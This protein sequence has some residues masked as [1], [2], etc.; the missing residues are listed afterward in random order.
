VLFSARKINKH[1][2][3]TQALRDVDFAV[4]AGTVHALVGENGAGKSTLSKIVAGV[5]QPDSGEFLWNGKRV[6]VRNPVAAQRLGI[7]T[8]F[9][10]LDV[11]PHLSVADNLALGTLNGE[12]SSWLDRRTTVDFAAPL[13]REVGLRVDPGRLV[14][15]LSIAQMQLVLIARALGMNARLLI[16]DEPTSTLSEDYAERL[17]GLIDRLKQRGVAIIYVSHKMTEIFRLSDCITVLRDGAHIETVQTQETD[18]GHIVA[19]MIGRTLDANTNTIAAAERAPQDRKVVLRARKLSSRKLLNLSFDLHEGEV[20]GVAG[21][22]GSGRSSL[23]AALFGLDSSVSGE[24]ELRGQPYQPASPRNAIRR[25]IGLLPEDRKTM[26]LMMQMSVEENTTISILDRLQSFGFLR[27]TEA[28]DKA[29]AMHRTLRLKTLRTDT[30]IS[31]LS[32]GNQQKVLL[33]RWLLVNPGV[34]ILDDPTRGVDVGAKFD[35]YRIIRSLSDA[36]KGVILLSSELP[37]LLRCCDRI[38]VLCDGQ[39]AGIL[40]RREATQENIM[41]LATRTA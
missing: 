20:L 8:I 10:E 17:F 37:E 14:A 11:F 5:M 24:I 35:I 1:F 28:R 36:G 21:L 39:Q 16:M 2:D 30:G 38:M 6:A 23:G 34:M 32:G 7:G 25:G 26:G 41:A 13:M 3:G 4:E 15:D 31:T 40:S 22:V 18:I 29:A 9:Q 12:R 27:T 19:M 33:A